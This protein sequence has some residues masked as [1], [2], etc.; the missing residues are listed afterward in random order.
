[1]PSYV[2]TENEMTIKAQKVKILDDRT[3][4][5]R[6]P[7]MYVGSTT[8]EPHARFVFG[9]YKTVSYVP[10]IVK[11]IDEIIDNSV[12]EAIRTNFQFANKIDVSID[13]A[14]ITVKDN[15][16]GIPQ[17]LIE[18]ENGKE[19]PSPVAAWTKARSGGNFEDDA[20]RKT[21]GMNGVGSAL[22]NFFSEWFTGTTCDGENTITVKC[23]DGASNVSWSTKKNGTQG[24]TVQFMPDFDMFD[25]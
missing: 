23:T 21:Q 7:N 16:R 11:I 1:M 15:G 20:E 22:T 25:G 19:I 6:R 3:H 8:Y 14:T 4:I 17:E 24:T 10:G 9:E 18:D 13:G 12:D 5:R 2:C